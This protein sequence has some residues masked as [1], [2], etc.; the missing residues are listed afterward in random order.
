MSPAPRCEVRQG[1][2]L[3]ACGRRNLATLGMP[4]GLAGGKVCNLKVYE[5]Q[6][7]SVKESG[8][9]RDAREPERLELLCAA[10]SSTP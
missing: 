5:D 3:H 4:S 9:A 8:Q 7:S 6:Q 10:S 1:W 2:Q